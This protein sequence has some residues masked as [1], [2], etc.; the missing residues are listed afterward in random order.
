VRICP[1]LQHH[2]LRLL[3]PCRRRSKQLLR[4]RPTRPQD[5]LLQ[6]Q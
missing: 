3:H 4:L 5:L 1:P 6:C 2:S